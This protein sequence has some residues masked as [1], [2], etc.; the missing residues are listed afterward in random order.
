M[1][2]VIAAL[3]YLNFREE[4]RINEEIIIVLRE[5]RYLI[6]MVDED[7]LLADWYTGR[8]VFIV[9]FTSLRVS[10]CSLDCS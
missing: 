8:E 1:L 5:T 3:T 4:N 6:E 9:C 2:R 7:K 10:C